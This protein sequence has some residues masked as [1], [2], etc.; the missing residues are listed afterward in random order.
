MSNQKI[1]QPPQKENL[2]RREKG[3]DMNEIA[4]IGTHV[5]RKSGC[6]LIK[7]LISFYEQKELIEKFK[8]NRYKMPTQYFSGNPKSF[9]ITQYKNTEVCLE[10]IT[11][12]NIRAYFHAPYI[13]NL[14]RVSSEI[15]MPLKR[16]AYELE[17]GP[18]LG[19]KGVVVH[20][21]KSLKIPKETALKNMRN[22]I[23][24]M[25]EHAS[26]GCPLLI[27]TPAGQGTELLTNIDDFANF[28]N[29]FTE[30]QRKKLGVCV[31]TC[32][33]FSAG[34]DP[35]DYLNKLTECGITVNLLHYNDSKECFGSRK[36]RHEV[37]GCGK[38]PIE[39]LAKC[40]QKAI[41][42]NISI[43]TEF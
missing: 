33:V 8:E 12:H 9:A 35:Y 42:E 25:L 22:N 18:K 14:A 1:Y 30:E 2:K 27:E 3:K 19:F 43:V 11:K 16:L 39:T 5:S 17:L 4:N 34:Y 10:Y 28:Y 29:E 32:H 24:S 23:V 15:E 21:G 37:I 40:S 41:N 7:T 31:D 38:I 6:N 13:I 36:D 26:E 20:V